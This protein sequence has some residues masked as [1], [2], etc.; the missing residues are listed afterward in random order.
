MTFADVAI[1]Y[2][3]VFCEPIP[4]DLPYVDA[5]TRVQIARPNYREI[6]EAARIE[7]EKSPTGEGYRERD[8][9]IAQTLRDR[10]LK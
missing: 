5:A 3:A 4:S 10:G 1:V 7:R 6:F 8:S 2:Q 9:R